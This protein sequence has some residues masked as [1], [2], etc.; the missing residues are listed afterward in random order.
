MK[1]MSLLVLVALGVCLG[2]AGPALAAPVFWA[3]WTA[4]TPGNP[5]TV[6]GS[7]TGPDFG[8][9]AVTYTGDY[10]FANL[11]NTGANY[12][13]PKKTFADGVLVD[14]EPPEKDIIALAGGTGAA[15][16]AIAFSAPVVNPVM[17]I[18]SLGQRTVP[19]TYNFIDA[20]FDVIANGPGTFGNG[21]LTELD[22]NILEGREGHGTI[23]FLG[24]FTSIAW[25]IPTYEYWHGITVGIPGVA[26]PPT[27]PVPGALLLV[28]LGAGLVGGLRRRR[29]L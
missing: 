29:T 4:A 7:I 19:V 25:T 1:L 8:T 10:A 12:W 26:D 22:G 28:G 14:N 20:P 13:A 2:V 6:V 11:G 24:T 3:D 16:H 17:G 5:D 15:I 21:P 27:V 9:V 23:R 18:V